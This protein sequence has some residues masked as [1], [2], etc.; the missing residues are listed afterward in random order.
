MD[1]FGQKGEKAAAEAQELEEQI[2]SL[3][4]HVNAM[5]NALQDFESRFDSLQQS[6]P[7]GLEGDVDQNK[8]D[9][10]DLERIFRRLSRIQ[11]KQNE[12]LRQL[13]DSKK[14]IEDEIAGLNQQLKNRKSDSQSLEQRVSRLESQIEDQDREVFD[15][16]DEIESRVDEIEEQFILDSNRQEWDLDSKVEESK[17]KNR[18]K[19]INK[20]LSKLRTSVNS[21][22]DEVNAE[23]VEIEE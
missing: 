17:F 21:I 18:T 13:N 22:A 19:E 6:I 20:E 1:L 5:D 8:R 3:Q 14:S 23:K 12:K 7:E 2:Q 16:L 10:N 11:S 9:L 15:R 4:S